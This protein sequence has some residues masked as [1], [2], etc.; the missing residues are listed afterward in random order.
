MSAVGLL[1]FEFFLCLLLWALLLAS[2][3]FGVGFVFVGLLLSWLLALAWLLFVVGFIC[4]SHPS[5]V[6]GFSEAGAGCGAIELRNL[7]VACA[8]ASE[9]PLNAPPS[10]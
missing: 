6:S 1:L 10:R 5:R 3:A 4:W 8:P 9:K 7:P 2:L